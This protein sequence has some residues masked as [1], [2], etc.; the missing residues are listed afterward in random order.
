MRI[1]ARN[2]APGATFSIPALHLPLDWKQILI[3][4][5][6]MVFSQPS[7]AGHFLG[8]VLG[9]LLR[10]GYLRLPAACGCLRAAFTLRD[11]SLAMADLHTASYFCAW[12]KALP[13]HGDASSHHTQPAGR[14][15]ILDTYVG[16]GVRLDKLI[17]QVKQHAIS[18]ST[19]QHAFPIA[20]SYNWT[21]L[22]K[23]RSIKILKWGMDVSH[24]SKTAATDI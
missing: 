9:G 22:A 3:F 18:S 24:T 11:T 17:P 12:L 16:C 19:P 10:H 15:R 1:F 21:P 4:T 20:L 8:E 14:Q 23:P 7:V 5:N 2:V 13:L 6:F